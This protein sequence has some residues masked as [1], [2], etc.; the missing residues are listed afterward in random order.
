MYFSRVICYNRDVFCKAKNISILFFIILIS[1]AS[2]KKKK[3]T[4]VEPIK[5][6]GA[7]YL[8]LKYAK[9][10]E[11]NYY[12]GY[13]Q[14]I[15]KHPWKNSKESI[16][17]FISKDSSFIPKTLHTNDIVLIEPI[18]KVAVV[19]TTYLSFLE[20]INKVNNISAI[21]YA[22]YVYSPKILKL[23]NEQKIK[24]IGFDENLNYEKLLESKSKLIFTYAIKQPKDEA[25]L[26]SLDIKRVMVSEYL[27]ETP[28]AQAEWLFFFAAFFNE[29]EKAKVLFDSID[30]QYLALQKDIANLESKPTV[31]CNLPFKGNWYLPGGKSV[32][33]RFIEDAGGKYVFSENN[34]FGG[35]NIPYE[36]AYALALNADYFLHVNNCKNKK[37]LTSDFDA[38]KNTKAFKSNHIYNNNLRI[39][40]QSANDFWES[41]VAHPDLV[42]KDLIE[43]LHANSQNNYSSFY[44]R[45]IE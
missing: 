29:E 21:S 36:K 1:F 44:Y 20:M 27:E 3:K 42:L 16:N 14:I 5:N 17:Y 23:H 12:K 30:K 34:E 40:N 31:M 26:N 37:E 8:S 10:F 28:L 4:E 18:D 24:E 35:V 41:G 2:C 38:I 43:I 39:N 7:T 13:K 19:S 33:A 9:G 11:V 45:K 22:K 25:K 15:V 32:A 6:I